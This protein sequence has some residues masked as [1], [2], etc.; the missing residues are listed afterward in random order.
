VANIF[1][2]RFHKGPP[3]T[4]QIIYRGTVVADLSKKT[5]STETVYTFRY[6]PAFKMMKL[7]P[8]PGLPFSEI[9]R[10]S[11]DL[12]PF[13]AERIPDARRPEIKA[14]MSAKQIDPEDDI[15]LI[16]ELGSH[17]ITDPFEIQFAAA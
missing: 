17:S 2:S 14:W 10:Q 9:P 12:W 5:S 16:A 1:S 6:L 3:P 15:R 4:L 8:L 7:A 13:F 11:H